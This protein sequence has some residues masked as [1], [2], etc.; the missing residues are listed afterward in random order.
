MSAIPNP[1][2]TNVIPRPALWLGVAG[3]VPFYG[4]LFVAAMGWMH[5]PLVPLNALAIYAAMILSFVGAIWWG[6][7]VNAPAGT[8][9]ARLYSLSVIASLLGWVALLLPTSKG[10]ALLMAGFMAQNLADYGL[11]F[12]HPTIFPSWLLRLRRGL[13]VGVV[14]AL[15]IASALLPR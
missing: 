13:T 14:L 1:A 6:L 10:L 11:A 7:A 12:R 9:V 4:C 8:P 3:L 5:H 2:V 15:V